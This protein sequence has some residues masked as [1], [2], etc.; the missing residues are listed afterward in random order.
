MKFQAASG[1]IFIKDIKTITNDCLLVKT[2]FLAIY[3]QPVPVEVHQYVRKNI[4][5]GEL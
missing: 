4:I 5:L 2:A 1:W 3:L